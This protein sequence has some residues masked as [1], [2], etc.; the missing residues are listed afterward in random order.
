MSITFKFGLLAIL[1]FI[2]FNSLLTIIFSTVSWLIERFEWKAWVVLA[3]F[4]IGLL[5]IGYINFGDVFSK[6]LHVIQ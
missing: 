1:G 5:Y 4:A 2:I 3:L 6:L